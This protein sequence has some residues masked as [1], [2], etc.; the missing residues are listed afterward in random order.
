MEIYLVDFEEEDGDGFEGNQT[1]TTTTIQPRSNAN[2]A[3]FTSNYYGGG[4]Y[5]GYGKDP[6]LI[7]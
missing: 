6:Q 3:L 4:G 5:G 2:I 7:L 1:S